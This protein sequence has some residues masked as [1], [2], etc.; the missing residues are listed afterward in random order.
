MADIDAEFATTA[1]VE[2]WPALGSL[3]E[4]RAVLARVRSREPNQ[5]QVVLLRTALVSNEDVPADEI[6]D[7]IMWLD[8]NET[9]DGNGKHYQR[10]VIAQLYDEALAKASSA[11]A[12]IALHRGLAVYR[13][14]GSKDGRVSPQ[15]AERLAAQLRSS[16]EP[17][18]QRVLVSL[19]RDRAGFDEVGILSAANTWLADRSRTLTRDDIQLWA[20]AA[21]RAAASQGA[22]SERLLSEASDRLREAMPRVEADAVLTAVQLLAGDLFILGA[23]D[24]LRRYARHA[25]ATVRQAVIPGLIKLG[26]DGHT[27]VRE[28]IAG[29]SNSE[30]LRVACD[31]LES[32]GE[33]SAALLRLVSNNPNTDLTAR[34]IL[35][36]TLRGSQNDRWWSHLRTAWP[37]LGAPVRDALRRTWRE[38]GE[39]L[40]R[41][42]HH[43]FWWEFWHDILRSRVD[44]AAAAAAVSWIVR[45]LD[46]IVGA[47]DFESVS[48][49]RRDEAVEVRA[50]PLLRF[51]YL[52]AAQNPRGAPLKDVLRGSD[53]D[54]DKLAAEEEHYDAARDELAGLQAQLNRQA[55]ELGADVLADLRREAFR[56]EG[57]QATRDRIREAAYGPLSEQLREV[58]RMSRDVGFQPGGERFYRLFRASEALLPTLRETGCSFAGNPGPDGILGEYQPTDRSITLF[59]PMIELAGAE[60]ARHLGRPRGAIDPLVRTVVEV[61]EFAHA[62]L[63]LGA[64]ARRSI[65]ASPEDGSV[66]H[67]EALAQSYTRRLIGGMDEPALV[68]VLRVLEGWLPSEYRFADLLDSADAEDLRGWVVGAR[69]GKPEQTLDDTATNVIRALPGYLTL[70]ASQLPGSSFQTL[71]GNLRKILKRMEVDRAPEVSAELLSVVGALPQ[72]P[73]V[74]GSFLQ[75]GWPTPGRLNW[76]LFEARIAGPPSG[77]RPLRFIKR[78]GY[79]RAL[80]STKPAALSGDLPSLRECS[81]TLTMLCSAAGR[82]VED[83]RRPDDAPAEAA[84]AR[85][86]RGR[87]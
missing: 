67:H 66:A 47:F 57:P 8:G 71:M 50:L 44:G 84:G 6:M 30:V 77:D 70:V 40:E 13:P 31:A 2:P 33:D 37:T 3:E 55:A 18:E 80:S 29:D 76:L 9:L 61:H 21:S 63:H 60:V 68:D 42:F 56:G 78:D 75:G 65:W 24:A 54:L 43:P 26:E 32:A 72:A 49:L 14:V 19:L 53:F 48:G 41:R 45:P 73:V 5:E 74:L 15:T 79:V 85:Q 52:A 1:G 20:S 35:R 46:E 69:R 59:S 4:K 28:M 23:G 10:G 36:R 27:L 22:L 11:K 82:T 83:E 87:R 64:D 25:D 38:D 34:L 81:A 7:V 12:R 16:R 62:H 58:E 51:A 86:K 39:W 17:E